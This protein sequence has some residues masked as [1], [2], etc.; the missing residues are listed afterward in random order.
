MF[1]LGMNKDRDTLKRILEGSVPKTL[2]D[3]VLVYVSVTGVQNGEFIEE[4]FVRKVYPQQIAGR[5]WGAIQVTTAAG[6]TS[7]VDL[8]LKDP[9]KYQGF[10]TQEQFRLGDILDNRFGRYYA[11][12]D[13]AEISARLVATGQTGTQR[14]SA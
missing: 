8:V 9:A 12:K 14:K 4:N 5:L 11:Q 2:Q 1:E 3:V 13:G 10:V 6:I 7:V